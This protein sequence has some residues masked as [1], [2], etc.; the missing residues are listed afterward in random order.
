M[1]ADAPSTN[2]AFI[3]IVEDSRTQAA[4]LRR[5]MQQNGYEAEI[6]LDGK[7]AIEAATKRIPDLVISDILMP[8][9]DGY[10]MCEAMRQ[11]PQLSEVPVMLLTTLIDSADIV[12]GLQVGA[13]YYIT[14]PYDDAYLLATV[15]DILAQPRP[16][17]SVE[18]Q[19]EIEVKGQRYLIEAGRRRMLNLLLSTYGNAVQQN[20]VLLQH[21]HELRTLND[22]LMAQRQQIAAQQR[23]LQE[24]NVRLLEQATRDGMTGLRNYRA[25]IERLHEEFSRSRRRNDTLTLMLL[26]IDHFKTY[27]DN[28]G[29][30]A[31]DEVLRQVADILESQARTGDMVAR[32]G[33][34]E[35]AML[36]P[37][38]GYR[39]S[40][41][42][43]DRMC[44]AIADA[45]W[46]QRPITISIG[47]TSTTPEVA[48]VATLI[49]RADVALY[50]SKDEGRNRSTHSFDLVKDAKK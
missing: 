6:A 34:E 19:L 11:H 4:L 26:D 10:E 48:D 12:R 45:P 32:Y 40:C 28:F 42:I 35:F 20:R 27:N 2:P 9:M 21:Q 36:L 8:V 17:R 7:L 22:Q 16:P 29:H 43:A 14:K 47:V 18:K 49:D 33:G 41:A 46:L 31:G 50:Y 30:P 13:D 39:E 38:T 1:Q 5:L 37:N 25:F 44:K 3:L 15:T 24:I 23:E